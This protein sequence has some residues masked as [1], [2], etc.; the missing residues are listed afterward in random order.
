MP[1]N[2]KFV[3]RLKIPSTGPAS[4]YLIFKDGS[5]L[6]NRCIIGII[7]IFDCKMFTRSL[8][9][10]HFRVT[11]H[12]SSELINFTVKETMEIYSIS[13]VP[14]FKSDS[15]ANMK[16]YF[17]VLVIELMKKVRTVG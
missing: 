5:A 14:V 3:S 16:K 10:L 4:L 6:G 2:T 15:A 9:L 1:Q 12:V 8:K 11:D 7:G 17:N 13:H